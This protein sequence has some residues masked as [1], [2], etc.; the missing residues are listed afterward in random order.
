MVVVNTCPLTTETDY[1]RNPQ[2]RWRQL[3]TEWSIHS[4]VPL[5]TKRVKGIQSCSKCKQRWPDNFR[6]VSQTMVDIRNTSIESPMP[7]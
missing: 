3:N 2:L 7:P 6:F 5:Q 1:C 4:L